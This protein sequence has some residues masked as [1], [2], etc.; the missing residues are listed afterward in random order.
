[1]TMAGLFM[2]SKVQ[3]FLDWMVQ[4]IQ[5]EAVLFLL[6]STIYCQARVD[7]V[8]NYSSRS[9]MAQTARDPGPSSQA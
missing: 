2:K 5:A 9:R 4:K 6:K 1:M 7:N 3:I 8:Q